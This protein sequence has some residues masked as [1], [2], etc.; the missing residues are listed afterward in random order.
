MVDGNTLLIN[1]KWLDF[2][3]SHSTDPCWLSEMGVT[4]G[5]F[6]C[7][8]TVTSLYGI[9]LEQLQK[10]VSRPQQLLTSRSNFLRQKVSDSLRYMPRMVEIASGDKSGELD[11]KLTVPECEHVF[12]LYGVDLECRVTLDRESTCAEKKAHIL[13][14]TGKSSYTASVETS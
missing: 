8:H 2:K 14:A 7:D 9:V 3:E 5:Q 11:V 6:P 12:K 10:G 13:F 4:D 1:E